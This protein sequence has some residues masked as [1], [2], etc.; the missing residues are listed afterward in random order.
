MVILGSILAV[1]GVLSLV[2]GSVLTWAATT[3]RDD[4][5]YFHTDTERFTSGSYAIVSDDIDL[6]TDARPRDWGLELGD[7]VRVRL[8][9]WPGDRGVPLFVGIAATDDVDRF[10]RDVAHDEVR[11]VDVHPF[12]AGYRS[13]PG[14]AE[15]GA[16]G[17]EDFWVASSG[18]P[19]H[20][21]LT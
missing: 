8:R 21:S 1:V 10:L 19:G 4:A 18:G 3:Q 9:A 16:P 20:R 15:P 6:G 12:R 11:D 14:D 17:D 2:A 7:L 13:F 5:G